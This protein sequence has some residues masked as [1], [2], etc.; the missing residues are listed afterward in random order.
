MNA[1]LGEEL[2]WCFATGSCSSSQE[3]KA[4]PSSANVL[5]VV[6]N[7]FNISGWTEWAWTSSADVKKGATCTE[8]RPSTDSKLSPWTKRAWKSGEP[9][10]VKQALAGLQ[11]DTIWVSDLSRRAQGLFVFV[12]HGAGEPPLLPLMPRWGL[13]GTSVISDSS[14]VNTN[15]SVYHHNQQCCFQVWKRFISHFGS[16]CWD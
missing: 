8:V 13:M 14:P 7:L 16:S 10:S 6:I 3:L 4:A 2:L 11:G 15:S 9:E 12:V 5:S 1:L